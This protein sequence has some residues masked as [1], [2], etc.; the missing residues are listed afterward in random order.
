MPPSSLH[1]RVHW[2]MLCH[3]KIPAIFRFPMHWWSS[4]CKEQDLFTQ[5]HLDNVWALFFTDLHSYAN[6]SHAWAGAVYTNC[7]TFPVELSS[8]R[9]KMPSQKVVCVLG[10]VVGI[11]PWRVLT[12]VTTM[13]LFNKYPS[14]PS[15]IPKIVFNRELD[16]FFCP[17][18]TE[19]KF[20]S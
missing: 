14:W 15:R 20:S 16:T 8:R 10:V 17:V 9:D 3:Q 7:K 5:I 18:L 2:W 12:R 13:K 4:L 19:L 11:S 6:P 1:Y